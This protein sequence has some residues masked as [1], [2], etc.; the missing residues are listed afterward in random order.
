MALSNFR[1]FRNFS[2]CG[3]VGDMAPKSDNNA[4]VDA[5]RRAM[6][7]ALGSA[8]VIL[9]LVPGSARAEYAADG[10]HAGESCVAPPDHARTDVCGKWEPSGSN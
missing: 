4:K 5:T 3:S 7:L 10:Y 8:P 6:V 9:T 2:I 1:Y